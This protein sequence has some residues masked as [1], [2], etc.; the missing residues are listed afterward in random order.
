MAVSA[1]R[2]SSNY[3]EFKRPRAYRAKSYV[4]SDY[5][6]HPVVTETPV[7]KRKVRVRKQSLAALLLNSRLID[8]ACA[9]FVGVA[10]IFF[11]LMIA[12]ML[13]SN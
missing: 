9:V 13:L 6:L 8:D 11:V 10:G 2:T 3:P 4:Y 12:R 5:R 7:K 1:F